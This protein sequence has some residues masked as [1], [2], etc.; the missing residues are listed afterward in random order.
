[1]KRKLKQ[2][3]E[4]KF[5]KVTFCEKTHG[6]TNDFVVACLM[7]ISIFNNIGV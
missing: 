4:T 2:R 3:I 6:E 7:A 1:M 5:V